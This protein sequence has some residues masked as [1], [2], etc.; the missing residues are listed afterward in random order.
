MDINELLYKLPAWEH[1]TDGERLLVSSRASV[2][3]YEPGSHLRSGAMNCLG[4]ISVISGSLRAYLLSPE[5]RE[6]TL[7]RIREGEVCILSAACVLDL[8]SF[9]SYIITEEHCKV[10]LVPVDIYTSIIKSNIYFECDTYKM[11]AGRFSDVVSGLERLVFYS[12]EQRIAAFL[13]DEASEKETDILHMTHDQIA[14]NIGSAR[15]AVSRV[16]KNMEAQGY[17]KLSRGSV[18]LMDK[19]GL[20]GILS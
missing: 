20:Y 13:I 11:A 7:Y 15:E 5:G 6:V 8:I 14:V 12:L 17:L 2:Q 1:L 10:L 9:D 19:R 16:L 3:E 18:E 4:L